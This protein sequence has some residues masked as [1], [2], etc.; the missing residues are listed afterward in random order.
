[1]QA[2]VSPLP[3]P[4]SQQTVGPGTIYGITQLSPSASAYTGSYHPIPSAG[5]SS[6]TQKE[7]LYPERP[8]QQECQYY[9]KTGDCKYGS[10]CRYHHPPEAITPKAPVVLN[11]HGLPM[12]PVR[13]ILSSA[14]FFFL[15]SVKCSVLLKSTVSSRSDASTLRICSVEIF[16]GRHPVFLSRLC[17]RS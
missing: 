7:H 2:P 14:A 9:M 17:R 16:Y 5:P 15:N 11:L 8:G 10:S 3:S 1:M 12:R 13:T 6:V 4:S